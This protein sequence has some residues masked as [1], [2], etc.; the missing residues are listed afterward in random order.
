M[1]QSNL[2]NK[3]SILLLALC[4]GSVTIAAPALDTISKEYP[5]VPQATILLIATLPTLAAIL[6]S[7]FSAVIY[8]VLGYK[9]TGIAA[10]LMVGLGGALPLFVPG[11]PVIILSR[12]IM[13]IGYGICSVLPPT[14]IGI[15]LAGDKSQ[16]NYYGYAVAMLGVSGVV[17]GQIG[18]IVVGISVKWLWAV[19]LIFLLILPVIIIG[20]KEPTKEELAKQSVSVESAEHTGKKNENML[21]AFP[22]VFFVLLILHFITGVVDTTWCTNVSYLVVEKQIAHAAT[23][24]GTLIAAFNLGAFVGGTMM[25]RIAKF[26]KRFTV[27]FGI[28]CSM[29]SCLLS[30]LFGNIVILVVAGF[31]IGIADSTIYSSAFTISGYLVP[32]EA[33]GLAVGIMNAVVQAGCF[34]G[35]YIPLWISNVIGQGTV[36]SQMG[37]VALFAAICVAIYTLILKSKASKPLVDGYAKNAFTCWSS[38]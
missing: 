10:V 13:G 1:K 11:F 8:K 18:G 31:I 6:A 3:I 19:H 35:P 22:A 33:N 15:T 23:F 29:I 20:M 4:Q 26:T 12:V 38:F 24:A 37:I 34:V 21:H 14:L 27:V 7:V 9:K 17:L 32:G 28:S 36:T 2:G 25:G 5:S 30:F 16:K